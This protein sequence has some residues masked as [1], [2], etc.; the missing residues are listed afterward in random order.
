MTRTL[1]GVLFAVLV[2]VALF[3]ATV[4]SGGSS[5]R[6]QPSRSDRVVKSEAEW[7]AELTS[8]EFEV[9]REQG[10]ERAY[11][12]EYHDDH[13]PGVY[14]CAACGLPLFSSDAT[15][16]RGTGWPSYSLRVASD[17]VDEIKDV[18]YGMIRT[19]VTC[20]RCG[21]HLGHVFDDGPAPTRQRYCINSVSLDKV[22]KTEAQTL[23][24]AL[25]NP[26][27]RK[28]K[29]KKKRRNK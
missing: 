5:E 2:A 1:W 19:E 13:V 25:A 9:L 23:E 10:T 12:G 8:Q 29:K 28:K 6:P 14:T 20:A 27:G 11:T 22:D 18:T 3:N 15:F 24:A 16:D 26:D 4:A 7:K 21:G 17:R